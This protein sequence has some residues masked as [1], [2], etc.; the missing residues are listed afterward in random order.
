MTRCLIMLLVLGFAEPSCV[1]AISFPLFE[2]PAAK[3][4]TI[5]SARNTYTIVFSSRPDPIPNNAPFTLE[6]RVYKRNRSAAEG[7]TLTVDGRMPQHRHGMN[8]EPKVRTLGPG[9]FMVE[10]MLFHMPG[11]WELYFDVSAGGVTER[12]RFVVEL[13]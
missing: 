12:A 7:V 13:E 9:R 2:D 1:R 8:R 10:G 5:S 3:T 6:V 11:R 4:Y